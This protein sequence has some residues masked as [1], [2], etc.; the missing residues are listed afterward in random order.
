MAHL[1]QI[2][3]PFMD[4]DS[5]ARQSPDGAYT[6]RSIYF[7]TANF[8]YYHEKINGTPNR[9]K[10]R[11]RGY[12]QAEAGSTVF[13][14]IKRKYQTPTQKYR[15]PLG[16]EDAKAVF[17]GRPVSGYVHNSPR[18]PDAQTNARRFF[19]HVYNQQLRPS[20]LVV[21]ERE[22]YQE[23]YPTANDL[24]I[25]FDRELRSAAYPAL[26][27]LYSESG[28]KPAMP[29]YFVLEIKFN[30][31]FPAWILPILDNLALKKQAVSKYIICIESQDILR[32]ARRYRTHLQTRFFHQS[33]HCSD[34]DAE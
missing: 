10:I 8:D 3:L 25:T 7:E 34:T 30:Q 22:A 26:D 31:Y 29:G 19:Y 16:F 2:V 1:R 12:N 33:E 32:Y 9:K 14:E 13:L 23:K 18:Y 24:R 6:V 20:V 28:T 21:Y 5:Y 11:I 4:Q 15:A 27:E 17:R